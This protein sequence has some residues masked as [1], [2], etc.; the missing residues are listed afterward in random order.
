LSTAEDGEPRRVPG[1]ESTHVDIGGRTI[2]RGAASE[3]HVRSTIVCTV[4]VG[5]LVGTDDKIADS[6]TIDV[7]GLSKAAS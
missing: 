7:T 3:D 1:N 5:G 6:V 4:I 2:N